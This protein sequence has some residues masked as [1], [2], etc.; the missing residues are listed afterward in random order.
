MRYCNVVKL[1][2][3]PQKEG[4]GA[5]VS[6]LRGHPVLRPRIARREHEAAIGFVIH[7]LLRMELNTVRYDNHR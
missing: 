3:V 7:H 6:G 4:R 2:I 5:G 1:I